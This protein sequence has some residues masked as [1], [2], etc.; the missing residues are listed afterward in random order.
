MISD[1]MHVTA[2]P[3]HSDF[4][5]GLQY[6]GNQFVVTCSIEPA[7][8]SNVSLNRRVT[9]PTNALTGT[10]SISRAFTAQLIQRQNELRDSAAFK[11]VKDEIIENTIAYNTKSQYKFKPT[12]ESIV[13]GLRLCIYRKRTKDHVYLA[14]KESHP[15]KSEYGKTL[16]KKFMYNNL[17]TFLPHYV[18][19]ITVDGDIITFNTLCS[20]YTDDDTVY[21]ISTNIMSIPFVKQIHSDISKYPS[22]Y[23]Y[24]YDTFKQKPFVAFVYHL[25]KG[26][27]TYFYDL[28][29]ALKVNDT[30]YVEGINYFPWRKDGMNFGI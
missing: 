7:T 2:T 24:C 22:V 26:T 6:G 1:I 20:G 11:K 13:A 8:E 28:I 25:Y 29:N 15:D 18:S 12:R 4:I 17:F 14:T 27:Y 5:K 23:L 9:I 3:E 16:M 21:G 30:E 19:D 10:G